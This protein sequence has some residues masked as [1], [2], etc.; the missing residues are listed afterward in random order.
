MAGNVLAVRRYPQQASATEGQSELSLQM[1]P[2]GAGINLGDKMNLDHKRLSEILGSE[3]SGK[4][5]GPTDGVLGS[6]NLAHQYPDGRQE[7]SE[8][9]DSETEGDE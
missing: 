9:D 5:T 4:A 3:I 8:T 7:S 1:Q 2:A 6:I